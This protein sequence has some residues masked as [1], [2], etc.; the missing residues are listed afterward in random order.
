MT[1][2]YAWIT[3]SNHSNTKLDSLNKDYISRKATFG[4][5]IVIITRIAFKGVVS[6][7]PE[8]R[9]K[10]LLR[11]LGEARVTHDL[12]QSFVTLATREMT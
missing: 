5:D 7:E 8:F 3:I 6:I 4:D 9:A 12:M 1:F 10:L 11:S 2:A